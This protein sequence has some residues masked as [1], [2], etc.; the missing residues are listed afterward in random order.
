MEINLPLDSAVS[1]FLERALGS[2]RMAAQ[3]SVPC[4]RSRCLETLDASIE[5]LISAHCAELASCAGA[6]KRSVSVTTNGME[7][8][9]PSE[10]GRGGDREEQGSVRNDPCPDYRHQPGGCEAFRLAVATKKA[11]AAAY[12]RGKGKRKGRVK[13]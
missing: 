6:T 5:K 1:L 8:G 12:L 4:V 7:T 9:T 11:A 3:A 2:V 13:R 10:D